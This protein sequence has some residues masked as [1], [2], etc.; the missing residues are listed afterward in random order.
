M[1]LK[2]AL[3]GFTVLAAVAVSQEMT[4][5]V[6]D[7]VYSDAQAKAGQELYASKC[8]SC[9]GDQLTGGEMAPPLAGP[10]FMA[11]WNGLSAGDLFERIRTTMPANKPG[12]LSR[13]ANTQI[14]A[15]MFASSK[16]PSGKTDMPQATEVLKTIK[17]ESEKPTKK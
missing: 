1:K 8:A 16:F 14:L 13:E 7:G 5:S 9:H 10:E 4:R 11:N 2:R 12:S 3:I 15:Y 6:W 17:I